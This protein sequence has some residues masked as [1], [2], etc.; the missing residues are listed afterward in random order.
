MKIDYLKIGSKKNRPQPEIA[1][2]NTTIT[3]ILFS[4]NVPQH[5][6]KNRSSVKQNGKHMQNESIRIKPLRVSA[7]LSRKQSD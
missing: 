6:T 1:P 2:D 4:V 7:K 5:S 3:L